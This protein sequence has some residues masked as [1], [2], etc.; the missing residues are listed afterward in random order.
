MRCG[1]LLTFL[2][3][4]LAASCA[5]SIP[6]PGGGGTDAAR[7]GWVIMS[8]D[9]DNPDRDF[10]CQSNPRTECVVPVDRANARVLAHVHMYYHPAPVETKYTGAIRIGFF[11]QPYEIKPNITVKPRDLP[12]NQSVANFVTNR[13]GTY[14]MAVDVLAEPTQGGQARTFREEVTV[15]VR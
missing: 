7:V 1:R 8:G 14:T 6:E 4:A 2:L 9:N 13:P 11:E 10:A 3:A 5:K 15:V 12:G